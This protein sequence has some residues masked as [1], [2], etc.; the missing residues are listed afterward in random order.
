MRSPYRKT[1]SQTKITPK[2]LVDELGIIDFN[3]NPE[4]I[5][6]VI[7]K[8]IEEKVEETIIKNKEANQ[9]EFRRRK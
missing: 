8:D 3:V 1:I 4:Y 7:L 6:S 5:P 9:N 2:G